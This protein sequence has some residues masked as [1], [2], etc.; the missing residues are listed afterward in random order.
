VVILDTSFSP[1]KGPRSLGVLG[2]GLPPR[3]LDTVHLDDL[4]RGKTWTLCK[5]GGPAQFAHEDASGGHGLLTLVLVN[6]LK[7]A[8]DENRDGTVTLAELKAF[9]IPMI[10]NQSTPSG[11]A[12][13]PL[14]LGPDDIAPFAYRKGAKSGGPK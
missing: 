2:R 3:N 6:G 14:F 4:K 1:E 13:V 8:A 11:K 12:Q 5:A 9:V 10:Q 7:G